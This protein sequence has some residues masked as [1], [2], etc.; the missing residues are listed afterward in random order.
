M[1]EAIVETN[2][3][4][5]QGEFLG[6]VY[7]FRGIP[8]A[9]PPVGTLRFKA[10]EKCDKWEGIYDATKFASIAPQTPSDV[11]NFLGNQITTMNEDC[12]Y[13]NIWSPAPDN[14]RRAVMVWI[15]GGAFVAGS[16]SSPWYDGRNFAKNGD[17]V[18]VTLNY[19]L[20]VFGFLH[21][22]ELNEHYPTSGNN[23]ILD[24]IAAIEWVKENIH[25]FG[26]DPERITVFGESAGAMSIGAM[27]GIP[28][29]RGLFQQVIL[30]SGAAHHTIS[31]KKGTEVTKQFLNLLNID[32]D[33]IDKLQQLSMDDLLQAQSQLPMMSLVPVVDGKVI[34]EHPLTAITKGSTKNL[35]MIIGTNKDEYNLFSVFDPL[36]KNASEDMKKIIFEKS[37]QDK[38]EQI[39]EEFIKDKPLT[40]DLYNELMSLQIFV[41]PA[42]TLADLHVKQDAP[43]WVYRFD[44]ETPVL[45]GLLKATHALE[46][47]FVWNNLENTEILTGTGEN[48]Q[49]VAKHMHKEWIHFAKYGEPS[50][51]WPKYE[52]IK[53]EVMSFSIE[54][55]VLKD[56]YKNVRE[57]WERVTMNH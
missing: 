41:N 5:V 24:Q 11:M 23:G 51:E 22:N 39:Q 16:G 28:K 33:N 49:I 47:P 44:W 14:K 29:A 19:R 26:G 12:L 38:W 13:L 36:W 27:L 37:F 40:L 9:K 35:K 6:D 45:G 46:I 48:R 42:Y 15:H 34:P 18:V 2:Y 8:Y 1:K 53:R 56:P 21:L 52:L 55:K 3:G 17:V 50:S 30:Q 43:V 31:S 20:G 32:E 10:P 54:K 7:V 57:K 25:H 4:K